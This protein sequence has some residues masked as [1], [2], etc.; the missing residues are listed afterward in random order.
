MCCMIKNICVLTNF[1]VF[2]D[3]YFLPLCKVKASFVSTEDRFNALR[4][5]GSFQFI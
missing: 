4:S 5:V 2:F 3:K 1:H